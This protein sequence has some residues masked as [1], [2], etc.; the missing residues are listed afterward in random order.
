VLISPLRGSWGEEFNTDPLDFVL[1]LERWASFGPFLE[2]AGSSRV[3]GGVQVI[4]WIGGRDLEEVQKIE[5]VG[6][7]ESQF[8]IPKSLQRYLLVG[9]KKEIVGVTTKRTNFWILATFFGFDPPIYC[10][11]PIG[12]FKP[13]MF[14]VEQ[15]AAQFTPPDLRIRCKFALFEGS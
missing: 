1:P 12:K 3:E 14:H 9:K 4:L 15:E 8:L 10:V 7:G 6:S 13:R 2:W 11:S 5:A